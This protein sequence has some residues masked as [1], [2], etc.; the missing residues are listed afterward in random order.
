MARTAPSQPTTIGDY[1]AAAPAAGQ[2][3][4]HELYA[5]LKNAAPQAE[6]AIKWGTPFFTEPRFV[7]AFSA[8][9]AH[10]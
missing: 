9:K 3:L 7:Y 4:L 2:P 5:I 10:A 8:H 6:E 1:I